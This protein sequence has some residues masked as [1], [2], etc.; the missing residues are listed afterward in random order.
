[1]NLIEHLSVVQDTRSDINQKHDLIDVMFLVISAIASGCEGW[2]D[3]ELFGKD[4][5]DWL[6]KYRTFEHGIPRRHT[7]ARILK[8]VV[9]ESLLE[10]LLNWVNEHREAHNKPIIAFDG[11]V[12]R[13]SYRNDRKT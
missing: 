13:G 8:A 3:I 9:A 7:V 5:L 1:M 6:R 2:Q 4:K 11:K 12:L 10:A